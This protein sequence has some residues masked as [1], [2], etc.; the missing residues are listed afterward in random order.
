MRG[1][2]RGSPSGTPAPLPHCV[3]MKDA[4]SQNDLFAAV[5]TDPPDLGPNTTIA[6]LREEA[7]HCTRCHLYKHATQTVFGAGPAEF[8]GES[9]RIVLIGE[10]PGDQEDLQGEPFVGPAGKLLDRALEEAGVDRS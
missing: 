10:Q 8:G 5:D 2:S 4:P 3:H 6:A 9:A 7:A 1:S